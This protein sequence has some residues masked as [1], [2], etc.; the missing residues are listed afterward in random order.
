MTIN[1]C[2]CRRLN[3]RHEQVLKLI[4]KGFRNAEI[5]KQLGLTERTIKGYVSQLLLAYDVTNRTELI[6]LFVTP[7][8][9]EP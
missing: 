3:E 1:H 9:T 4:A 7:E 2:S 5:G 8:Q 6:G